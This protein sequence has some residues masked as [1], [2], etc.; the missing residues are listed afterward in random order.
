[1][2]FIVLLG[3]ALVKIKNLMFSGR[4]KPVHATLAL[5]LAA[6]GPKTEKMVTPAQFGKRQG[7]H[8]IRLELIKTMLDSKQYKE[9]TIRLPVTKAL[10]TPS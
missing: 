9:H 3:P 7:R 2:L 4:M 8:E 5:V 10:R 6:C 1:M